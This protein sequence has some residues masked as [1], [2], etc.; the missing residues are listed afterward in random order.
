MKEDMRV[1]IAFKIVDHHRREGGQFLHNI[2][3]GEEK[4]VHLYDLG[5]K[6]KK[7][8]EIPTPKLTRRAKV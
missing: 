8:Y 4:W 2:V 3:T 6:N 1:D 7:S 5:G